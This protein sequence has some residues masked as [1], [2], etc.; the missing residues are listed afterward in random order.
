L[1]SKL[2]KVRRGNKG[3]VFIAT[4]EDES[5]LRLRSMGMRGSGGNALYTFKVID[6]SLV[7]ELKSRMIMA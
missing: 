2:A 3:F 5:S 4:I 1:K 7:V 6:G